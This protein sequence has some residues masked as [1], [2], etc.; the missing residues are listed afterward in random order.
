MTTIVE[1]LV[2]QDKEKLSNLEDILGFRFTDLRIL[3]Q[4]LIHSSYAF[5]RSQPEANNEILEFLGDAVLDLV[6]GHILY[7]HYSQM[8]EGE[9]TRFRAALVN[10][11]HLAEMAR[12]VSLGDFI[13]LGKGEEASSGRNKSSILSSAFE[14]VIGAV[15][16]DGGYSAAEKMVDTLF[17]PAIEGKKESLLAG[18]AKS[19]LQELLQ[20]K[21]NEAPS[22]RLD[23]EEGPSHKKLFTAS[24]LFQGNVLG[25]G[26]AGSKKEAEQ[27]AAAYALRKL[28][29]QEG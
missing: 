23:G 17:T 11:N 4:A 7:K 8:R 14:A 2:Q 3:Q 1:L 22:Y 5:E 27:Q 26:Q 25:T 6:I 18:D 9:L 10:E 29:H 16:E 12:Q 21:H 28:D 15:F 24:V 19:R 20:S 13:Y